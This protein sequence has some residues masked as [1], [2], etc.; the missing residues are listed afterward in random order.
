M[1]FF[2]PFKKKKKIENRGVY[3]RIKMEDCLSKIEK[4]QEKTERKYPRQFFMKP[5]SNT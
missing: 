3:L 2:P 4:Q 1:I 5:S